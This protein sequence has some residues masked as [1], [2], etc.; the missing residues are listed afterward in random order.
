[1]MA[2][3]RSLEWEERGVGV[4]LVVFE[5]PCRETGHRSEWSALSNH[6]LLANISRRVVRLHNAE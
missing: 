1:M 2:T 5:S 3:D 6:S 4:P